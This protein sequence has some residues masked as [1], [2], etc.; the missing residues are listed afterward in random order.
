MGPE[1]WFCTALPQDRAEQSDPHPNSLMPGGWS[2]SPGL[3]E[4]ALAVCLSSSLLAGR[5]H[6]SSYQ[7]GS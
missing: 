7:Q 3:V 5:A 2:S 6:S 4:P 1:G